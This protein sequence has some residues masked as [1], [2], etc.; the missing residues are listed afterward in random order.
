MPA[1][2]QMIDHRA[3]HT[4]APRQFVERELRITEDEADGHRV[5]RG[6]L[7]VHQVEAVLEAN[8]VGVGL[9][10]ALELRVEQPGV[11]DG[12]P[13][14]LL[15]VVAGEELPRQGERTVARG[16]GERAAE[17]GDVQAQAGGAGVQGLP[18]RLGGTCRAP[19]QQDALELEAKPS[20]NSSPWKCRAIH[21]GNSSPG[22]PARLWC[23]D[24]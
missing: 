15:G 6:P 10:I 18:R 23:T 2:A 24:T 9:Q 22:P 1:R 7:L 20:W 21:Q 11:A 19:P 5:V 8:D 14:A 3:L 4:V 16:R 12:C 17:V 13:V